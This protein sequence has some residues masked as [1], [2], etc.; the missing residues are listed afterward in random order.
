[1]KDI[2]IYSG[3]IDNNRSLSI[4]FLEKIVH[5]EL[6]LT[7]KPLLPLKNLDGASSTAELLFANVISDP[8]V[9]LWIFVIQEGGARFGNCVVVGQRFSYAKWQVE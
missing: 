9:K 4:Y 5:R 6:L 2:L 8:R 3:T 1:M 7:K